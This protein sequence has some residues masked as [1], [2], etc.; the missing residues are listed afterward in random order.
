M[1]EELIVI[2]TLI[3]C[4]YIKEHFYLSFKMYLGIVTCILFMAFQKF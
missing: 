2:V 3:V 4:W 1:K